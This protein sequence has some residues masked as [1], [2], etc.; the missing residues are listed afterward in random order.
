MKTILHTLMLLLVSTFLLS[1]AP[2]PAKKH[3]SKSAKKPAMTTVYVEKR[4]ALFREVPVFDTVIVP[5]KKLTSR[6]WVKPKGKEVRVLKGTRYVFDPG[7]IYY[8]R[9]QVPTS[10]VQTP[11]PKKVVA[12][13]Q[14]K[15]RP[16]AKSLPTRTATVKKSPP[17]P[18]PKKEPVVAK[19]VEK[20][21]PSPEPK[22]P[23]Q[24]TQVGK[25]RYPEKLGSWK[26][27]W[28]PLPQ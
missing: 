27:E 22:E 3:V 24:L 17:A 6:E 5:E 8:D 18:A 4:S 7:H 23:K 10:M 16:I 21:T 1:C 11:A 9:V 20:P 13:T 15:P 26:E 2:A 19:K 12:K 25:L 28:G 14:S